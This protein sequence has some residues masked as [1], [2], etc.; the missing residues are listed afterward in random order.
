MKVLI[1]GD[2]GFLGST[3]A[4]SIET[5]RPNSVFGVSTS[6]RETAWQHLYSDLTRED[7]I[8]YVLNTIKPD[9]VVNCVART[10][11]EKCEKFHENSYRLNSVIP[12]NLAIAT[13]KL[14]IRLIHIGTDHFDNLVE[15]S[16]D[17]YMTPIPR[18]VY[19]HSKVIG[20]LNLLV[21]NRDALV[22]RTNFFGFSPWVS[23]GLLS[24]ANLEL[25]N[26]KRINGF[27]NITFSPVGL[28][29]LIQIIQ[30]QFDTN[31]N[32]ILHLASPDVTSKFE[33]LVKFAEFANYDP[34]LIT[35]ALYDN[36][37]GTSRPKNM[38]LK[39][40]RWQSLGLPVVPTTS[41]GLRIEVNFARSAGIL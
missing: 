6:I 29:F 12:M 4:H 26:R 39:S 24:W 10:D 28:S 22:L 18:N 13:K 7:S 16:R 33:F 20:E 17:E 1:L 25:K 15:E 30:E 8:P 38:E 41:D 37:D 19:G 34:A 2:S 31:T 23:R 21:E 27:H 40:S 35:P 36:S 3:L 32:G 11:V 9:V 5:C 14:G